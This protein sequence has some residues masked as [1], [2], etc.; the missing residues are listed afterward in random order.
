MEY[1]QT[2][3]VTPNPAVTDALLLH[4]ILWRLEMTPTDRTTSAYWALR[5][6]FGV[7]PLL[8]GLD[9]FLNLLA[10]WEKY[11]SP[12]IA[13]LLPISPTAL[14]HVVGFIEI[15]VGLA[16]LTRWTRLGSYVAAAWLVGI[17][18]NLVIA[19]YL[20]VAVRDLVMAVAAYTLARL[21]EERAEQ[22]V[23]ATR[24]LRAPS[25]A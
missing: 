5:I 22:D 25:V 21:S 2:I 3:L 24:P 18:A 14:M 6:A 23:P 13:G 15:A 8:A 11:V 7:V 19:G 10:N 12:S 1:G 17:A 20:D 4:S 16:I 9:K